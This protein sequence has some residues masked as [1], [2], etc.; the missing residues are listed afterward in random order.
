MDNYKYQNIP[1]DFNVK[2]YIDNNNSGQPF[3]PT[4][5]SE[6]ECVSNETY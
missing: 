5:R 1:N 3:N 6:I 4:L 2:I